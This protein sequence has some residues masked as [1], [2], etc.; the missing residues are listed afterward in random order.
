VHI[1]GTHRPAARGPDTARIRPDPGW[2]RPYTE[3]VDRISNGWNLAKASWRV[4][5][6]DRELVAIPV[7]AGLGSILAFAAIAGGG[8]LALGGTDAVDTGEV[9]LWL[10]FALAAVVTTWISAIGQAA[11]IAGASQRMDGHDPTLGSAFD[12]ARS[13][14]GR[15][16][17]WAILATIVAIV[18]DQIEQRLGLLGRIVSWIGSVAF[19]V[20]SF[21][22]LPIIV[23]EDVGAIEAFKRSSRMLKQTWG[24]QVVFNFGIGIIGLLAALPAVLLAAALLATG[25]VAVQVVGVAAAVV[26]IVVVMAVTSALS[27]TFKA[28]LYRWATGRPVD[29]AFSEGELR[30][31]FRHR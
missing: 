9:A 4:L 20:L 24:E 23:F 21:L 6:Q 11:V 30:T 22:A 3:R 1:T 15:L 31:A 13:R 12:A 26:W 18:L 14:L 29:P 2:G 5:A 17:E 10:V 27:A 19:S 25:V 16:L 7:L 28:A 8:V